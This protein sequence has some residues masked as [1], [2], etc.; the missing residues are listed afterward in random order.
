MSRRVFASLFYLCLLLSAVE[1]VCA[2]ARIDPALPEAPLEHKRELFLFAG[3]GVVTDTSAPVPP[4]RAKQ[5]FEM[6]TLMMIDTSLFIRAG[7]VSAC[8]KAV[9]VGPNYGSGAGGFWTLYGYNAANVASSYLFGNAVMPAIFHQDPRYFRKGS[10]SAK[11]RIGWALRSQV[12]A[13]SDHGTEMP[14]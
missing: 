7:V 10:G 8:D 1:A 3:Y 14:N 4:L 12:V 6:A 5:K 11:S 13:F 9:Q 2:Q